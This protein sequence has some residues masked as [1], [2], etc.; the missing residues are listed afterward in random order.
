MNAYTLIIA[1]R[2]KQSAES[3]PKFIKEKIVR[4]LGLLALNPYQGKRLEGEW[5]SCY[6]IRVWPYRII[7]RI[8]KEKLIVFVLKIDHRKDV[9]R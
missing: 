4:R 9:Y 3:A 5:K 7:Y 1:K 6:A 8:E 2:A